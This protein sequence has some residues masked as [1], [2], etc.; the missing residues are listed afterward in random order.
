MDFTAMN[1]DQRDQLFRSFA[2]RFPGVPES[3]IQKTLDRLLKNNQVGLLSD[4]KA[5]LLDS[6]IGTK[7]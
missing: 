6:G 2:L 7:H 1:D 5:V 3:Q 4:G